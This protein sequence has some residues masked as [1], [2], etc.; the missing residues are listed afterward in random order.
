MSSDMSSS[1]CSESATKAVTCLSL[2]LVVTRSPASLK[3]HGAWGSHRAVSSQQI[4][5]A[6]GHLPLSMLEPTPTSFI[7]VGAGENPW[8]SSSGNRGWFVLP[9]ERGKQTTT[10]VIIFSLKLTLNRCLKLEYHINLHAKGQPASAEKRSASYK[11]YSNPYLKQHLTNPNI[12]SSLNQWK[13]L[14]V[15]F[16]DHWWSKLSAYSIGNWCQQW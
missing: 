11:A 4:R 5:L 9:R 15:T 2:Q 1:V 10:F 14:I 6:N 8:A 13:M 12:H 3:R 16:L 7:R